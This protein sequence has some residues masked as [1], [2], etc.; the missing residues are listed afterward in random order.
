MTTGANDSKHETFKLSLCQKLRIRP[1]ADDQ[2]IGEAV[3]QAV[4]AQSSLDT[5]LE[6]LGVKDVKAALDGVPKLRDA[7]AQLESARAELEDMLG[8]QNAMDEMAAE[9]EVG[10]VMKALKQDGNEGM[11]EALLAYRDKCIKDAVDAATRE[12]RLTTHEEARLPVKKIL[13]ARVVGRKNFLDK[14]GLKMD[15]DTSNLT[16]TYAASGNGQQHRTPPGLDIRDRSDTGGTGGTG[17]AAKGE[18]IDL[19]DAPGANP[20]DKVVQYLSGKEPD[21]AKLAHVEKVR[22][23]VAFMQRNEV[24]AVRRAG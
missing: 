22:R 21:F 15:V 12:L 5:L 13:A 16:R 2:A 18:T 10:A 8:A 3:D 19:S 6:A 4:G 17:S 9:A 23:A 24:I 7:L 11:K 14:Y 1:L 20:T